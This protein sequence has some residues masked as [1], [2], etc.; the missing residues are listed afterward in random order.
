LRYPSHD[1]RVSV[2]GLCGEYDVPL[3]DA[4]DCGDE[5][6]K[7][8]AGTGARWEC[9]GGGDGVPAAAVHVAVV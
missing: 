6:E 3:D 4:F 2:S 7:L 9:T 1:K 5:L 8:E